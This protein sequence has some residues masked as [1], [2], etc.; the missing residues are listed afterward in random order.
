MVVTTKESKKRRPLQSNVYDV[1]G[2]QVGR[3]RSYWAVEL[4]KS[5]GDDTS[6]V[7]SV[8]SYKPVVVGSYFDDALL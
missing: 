5:S 6:E 4:K 2:T 8:T 1:H 3:G 7:R